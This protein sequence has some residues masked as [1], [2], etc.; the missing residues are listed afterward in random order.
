M[1]AGSAQVTLVELRRSD[2]AVAN[3]TE[4]QSAQT[5]TNPKPKTPK[6]QRE[7]SNLL[8]NSC[9]RVSRKREGE[10]GA[11]NSAR[12]SV[13]LVPQQTV[14]AMRKDMR[15]HSVH[16]CLRKVHLCKLLALCEGFMPDKGCCSGHANRLYSCQKE[17]SCWPIF[18]SLSHPSIVDD[19]GWHFSL[20]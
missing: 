8:R 16:L 18:A 5:P 2:N 10:T 20:A 9:G 17:A 11:L 3:Q 15:V 7:R 13:L 19:A 14:R 12:L 6:H 4:E 1:C